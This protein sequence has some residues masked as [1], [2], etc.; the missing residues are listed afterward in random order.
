MI[1]LIDLDQD[2]VDTLLRAIAIK[3]EYVTAA[4]KFMVDS[5]YQMNTLLADLDKER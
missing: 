1:A 4:E 3:E 2:K 5:L